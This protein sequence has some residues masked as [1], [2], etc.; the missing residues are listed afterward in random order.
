MRSY[1]AA[2]RPSMMRA[3]IA[4]TSSEESVRSLA[5]T[6]SR[7]ERLRDPSGNVNSRRNAIDAPSAN[8]RIDAS[9][10]AIKVRGGATTDR[11]KALVGNRGLLKEGDDCQVFGDTIDPGQDAKMEILT[12]TRGRGQSCHKLIGTTLRAGEWLLPYC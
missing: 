7:Y 12:D 11:S 8:L 2:R 1:P 5:P 3:R 10:S 6:V 4:P 9:T